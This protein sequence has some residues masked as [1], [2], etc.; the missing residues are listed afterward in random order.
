MKFLLISFMLLSL[1]MNA[2]SH[3]PSQWSLNRA[4]RDNSF[5]IDRHDYKKIT[6]TV[7]IKLRLSNNAM[8][9][10]DLRSIANFVQPKNIE[11]SY[12]FWI[13]QDYARPWAVCHISF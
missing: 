1:L 5:T 8:I 12:N 2:C 9:D 6:S 3:S 7:G 13:E 4:Y 10:L 11:E